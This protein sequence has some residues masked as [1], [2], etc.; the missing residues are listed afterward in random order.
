[1][2]LAERVHLGVHLLDKPVGVGCMTQ[3]ATLFRS[4]SVDVAIRGNM[5]NIV[6]IFLFLF[7]L[8]D[9]CESQGNIQVVGLVASAKIRGV[10]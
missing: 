9:F 6:L 3:A 5:A 8:P 7:G 10:Y 1:M 4:P 2:I